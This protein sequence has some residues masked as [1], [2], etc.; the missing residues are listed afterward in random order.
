MISNETGKGGSLKL[1]SSR[2]ERQ[3]RFT[4]FANYLGGRWASQILHKPQV[5]SGKCAFLYFK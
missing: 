3:Q 1:R 2:N 5:V 4:S